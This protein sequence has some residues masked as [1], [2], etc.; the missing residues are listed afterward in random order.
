MQVCILSVLVVAERQSE[1][2]HILICKYLAEEMSLS[3][4]VHGV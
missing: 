3:Q 2:Q 1:K 4:S